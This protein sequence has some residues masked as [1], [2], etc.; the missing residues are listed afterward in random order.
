MIAFV[1]A[2]A[3]NWIGEAALNLGENVEARRHLFEKSS[4][5]PLATARGW[6]VVGG[7]PSGSVC[8][9]PSGGISAGQTNV[10]GAQTVP[11]ALDDPCPIPGAI[12]AAQV[13][14]M[15]LPDERGR[16]AAPTYLSTIC[17]GSSCT[18]G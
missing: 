10:F 7:A 2:D 1:L 4:L 6:P 12:T 11:D 14:W 13:V 16:A 9:A 15:G 3:H 5:S 8:P 18:Q 17:V